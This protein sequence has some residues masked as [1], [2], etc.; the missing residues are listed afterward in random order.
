MKTQ[1]SR[2][3][4]RPEKNYSGVYLQQGRLITDAD[5]N[6]LVEVVNRRMVSTL[7]DV[8]GSG[9]PRAGGLGLVLINGE[10]LTLGEFDP[11]VETEEAFNDRVNEF[12]DTAG[13]IEL[14]IQPG[15]ITVD[16]VHGRSATA[17]ADG[18]QGASALL[19]LS[20]QEDFPAAPEP[21]LESIDAGGAL[22]LYADVWE[23]TVNALEDERLRD[24]AL[25]GADTASRTQ[26]MV[27]IKY[28]SSTEPFFGRPELLP[29]RGNAPLRLQLRSVGAD[30]ES[31]AEDSQ[32]RIGNYL[33][34]VEVHDVKGSAD[35]PD[36]ITL[37][38]SRENGA[39][40]YL[41][42]TEQGDE[43]PAPAGFEVGPWVY[44]TYTDVSEKHLGVHLQ[45]LSEFAPSRGVLATR[46]DL[47][48]ADV[49]ADG[50]G[51]RHYVRRWDG[52]CTLRRE[53]EIWRLVGDGALAVDR[54]APLN[55]AASELT[56]GFLRIDGGV[57]G[58]NLEALR[59]SLELNGRSFVAGDYWNAPVRE[60]EVRAGDYVLGS[61]EGGEA[62]R[63]IEHHYQFLKQV[64]SA[65]GRLRLT[66]PEG[67]RKPLR[68]YPAL[69]GLRA[70]DV[71]V[72]AG[73]DSADTLD[74][75]LARI[76]A[77]AGQLQS[78]L[79]DLQQLQ[80][81]LQTQLEQAQALQTQLRGDFDALDGDVWR[82][83]RDWLA[84]LTLMEDF[85]QEGFQRLPSGLLI[86]WG[87]RDNLIPLPGGGVVRVQLDFPITHSR[88]PHVVVSSG[89]VGISVSI[90]SVSESSCEVTQ[91]PR[92]AP[93]PGLRAGF[94]AIG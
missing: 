44:E 3:T 12:F 25:N 29:A 50:S 52:C 93:L 65:D 84:N 10:G 40:N 27:Q 16:G 56:H 48:P 66:Q 34:R 64:E 31:D 51:L 33:F 67:I 47:P 7:T 28:S 1:I 74:Q 37:K 18:V 5:W 88:V 58:I 38:W 30:G 22:A 36:E 4:H 39:E 61:A 21:P 73:D 80:Q 24:P 19:R 62:P 14:R 70:A 59:L 17:G 9:V 53:G 91:S 78:Q 72:T 8:V 45:A 35:N 75:A 2:Q 71:I 57:L 43:L 87:V 20:G 89:T 90:F 11:A 60:V 55:P 41:R 81:T 15:A 83:Q 94:I 49:G 13:P 6:E 23:R 92:T 63:G 54:E 69:S 86:S 76:N 82:I 77:L 85:P 79:S 46:N 42:F 68:R 26:T 32:Q